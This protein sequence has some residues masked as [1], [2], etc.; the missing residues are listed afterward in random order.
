MEILATYNAADLL[1]PFLCLRCEKEG[2]S[3]TKLRQMLFNA[4]MSKLWKVNQ[5]LDSRFGFMK[6]SVVD[7]RRNHMQNKQSCRFDDDLRL[8]QLIKEKVLL[9]YE[10]KYVLKLLFVIFLCFESRLKY[11]QSLQKKVKFFSNIVL[12]FFQNF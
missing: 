6:S 11:K 5:A 2:F 3:D 8:Q 1:L 7:D 12:R 10:I 4:Y 9:E